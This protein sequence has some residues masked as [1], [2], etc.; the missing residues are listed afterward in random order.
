MHVR[1]PAGPLAVDFMCSERRSDVPSAEPILFLHPT[2]LSGRCWLPVARLLAAHPRVLLDSRG[3]GESHMNGPFGIADY[4]A[5]V[6][7]AMDA[8]ELDRSHLV[9]GSLG[10]S[11]A[12]AVAAARPERVKSII[13]LGGAL[14]PADAKTLARLDRGLQAG[15][16]EALFAAMLEHEVSV[17]LAQEDADTARSQLGL[18]RRSPELIR[19]ITW[20]AFSEDARHYAPSVTC[21]VYVL[22]GEFD[23]SCP[24]DAGG[25]MAKALGAR[26]EILPSCGHLAMLQS[27]VLIAGKLSQFIHEVQSK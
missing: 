4:A 25:R 17:G 22:T 18:D 7:A 10:G 6:C 19:E 27:P 15:A 13:A 26:F 16:I 14:E 2:N 12:C 8:L 5:D 11:I 21:P 23:D 20:N 24:P 9:G 1:G 3:H